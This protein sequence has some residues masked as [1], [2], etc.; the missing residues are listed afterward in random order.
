MLPGSCEGSAAAPRKTRWVVVCEG[1]AAAPCRVVVVDRSVTFR[2]RKFVWSIVCGIEI[3]LPPTAPSLH[4]GSRSC[5]PEVCAGREMVTG[6][7]GG[8]DSDQRIGSG[9][10]SN[11]SDKLSGHEAVATQQHDQPNFVEPIGGRATQPRLLHPVAHTR[12]VLPTVAIYSHAHFYTSLVASTPC[13]YK[14]P[15]G[16]QNHSPTQPRLHW[17]TVSP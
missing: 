2:W 4:G 7:Q 10:H 5:R 14:H 3:S 9:C 1:S 13:H 8:G 12:A 16:F 15:R 6:G 17:R 11:R